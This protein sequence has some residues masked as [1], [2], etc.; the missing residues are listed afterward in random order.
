MIVRRRNNQLQVLYIG[1]VAVIEK[2]GLPH[3]IYFQGVPRNVIIDGECIYSCLLYRLF[4]GVAYMLGF[5]EV[6]DVR[7]DGD[8][9]K[10]RFGAPSRELYMGD[11]PFKGAFGGE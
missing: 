10:I 2:D 5:G 11:Y 6:I 9:H 3:K 7:I 1:Q 4:S 8:I